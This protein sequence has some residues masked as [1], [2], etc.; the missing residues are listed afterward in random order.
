[1]K[2]IRK[3]F[4]CIYKKVIEAIFKVVYGRIV[5]NKEQTLFNKKII[6]KKS[7]R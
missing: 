6:K 4:Q 1:M 5:Y 7:T 3:F 2:K